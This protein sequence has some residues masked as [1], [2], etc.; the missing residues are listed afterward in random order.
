MAERGAVREPA[1]AGDLAQREGF[2][3]LGVEELS[4][5]GD[6]VVPGG[7]CDGRHVDSVYAL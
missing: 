1:A 6:Q 4:G 3:A 5:R 7:Q 2:E